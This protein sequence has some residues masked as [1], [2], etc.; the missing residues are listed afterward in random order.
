MTSFIPWVG[1]KA[2]LAPEIL[3]YFP[4]KVRHYYE[5]FCGSCAVGLAYFKQADTLYFN[6]DNR[7]LIDFLFCAMVWPMQLLGQLKAL[8]WEYDKVPLEEKKEFYFR[9]RDH[10][11]SLPGKAFDAEDVLRRRAEFFFLLKQGFQ[12]LW[13]VNSRGQFNVP[14]RDPKTRPDFTYPYQDIITFS[15]L[16]KEKPVL[17]SIGSWK[18]LIKE[19]KQEMTSKDLIYFDPPYDKTFV[20]YRADG[21]N[22]NSQKELADT[23]KELSDMGIKCVLSNSYTDYIQELYKDYTIIVLNRN[24]TW[25]ATGKQGKKVPECLIL[26]YKEL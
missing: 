26:S 3:K 11:N 18:D 22:S 10:F 16:S 20:D 4:E 8:A 17:L 24:N 21:F 5:P 1:G 19:H 15:L 6:D 23:F 2:K 13:R 7:D 12:S 9:I 14:P 25:G